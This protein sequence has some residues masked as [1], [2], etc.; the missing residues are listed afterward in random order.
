MI[1][2]MGGGAEL[3]AIKAAVAVAGWRVVTVRDM[4]SVYFLSAAAAAGDSTITINTASHFYVNND[5]APLGTGATRE[6]ITIQSFAGATLT[7]AA[8]LASAHA[9]GEPLEFPA[10]GWSGNPVV[11]IEGSASETEL[12]WTIGHELGHSAL[13]LVDVTHTNSVM[14]FQQGAADHRLRYK[15]LP[16]HYSAG[17]ENQWETIP[18]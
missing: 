14:H 2:L 8:P 15:P 17:D 7:L 10:A 5:S 6:N 4:V 18:R 12:K 9:V 11:I 1:S 13:S 16:K 3:D